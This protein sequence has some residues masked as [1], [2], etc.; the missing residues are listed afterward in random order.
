[1]PC[2][3][4]VCFVLFAS[5]LLSGSAAAQLPRTH[6]IG[7]DDYFTLGTVSALAVSPDG[8]SVAYIEQRWEGADDTRNADLW[9]VD[10]ATKARQRLTFDRAE[11]AAPQWSPDSRFLYFTANVRRPGDDAPPHDGKTQVWRIAADG[12]GLMAVTR[13]KEGIGRAELSA[14]G[15]ALYYTVVA[16][17]TDDEWKELRT[18]HKEIEYGHGVTKFTQVWRLDLE[19]WRAEKLVD[20]KRVVTALRVAPDQARIAM[21]TT[22]DDELLHLEGWSRID[23]WHA[24]TRTIEVVDRCGLLSNFAPSLPQH[25]STNCR[26]MSMARD[27]SMRVSLLDIHHVNSWNLPT[28]RAFAFRKASE[29]QSA[30][31]LLDR[32]HSSNAHGDFARCSVAECGKADSLP[33]RRSMRSTTISTG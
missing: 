17:G 5:L 6:E 16:E 24:A 18:R 31:H 13:V 10:V 8:A 4:A 30:A 29:R 33:Q 2:L 11:E 1:M 32:A 20:E 22:P 26:S 9:I 21:V 12:S 3:R 28:Q 25:A 27:F 15:R 23:V 7:V 14:D 19:S